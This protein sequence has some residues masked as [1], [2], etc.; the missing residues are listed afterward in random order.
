MIK[1]NQHINFTHIIIILLKFITVSFVLYR[2]VETFS[3]IGKSE[4]TMFL[5][6]SIKPRVI[7]LKSSFR[8]SFD[9]F[10]S[11]SIYA[12]LDQPIAKREMRASQKSQYFRIKQII[13]SEKWFSFILKMEDAN[14]SRSGEKPISILLYAVRKYTC[15]IYIL[16]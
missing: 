5:S 3:L 16:I 14:N 1:I 6:Y 12:T 7:Y 10:R 13:H 4:C 8:R 9:I 11:P 15:F 2:W